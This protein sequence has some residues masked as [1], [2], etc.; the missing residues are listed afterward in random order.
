MALG[1]HT[2]PRR[3]PALVGS[4]RGPRPSAGPPTAPPPA[5]AA[6]GSPGAGSVR[7]GPGSVY[8]QQLPADRRCTSAC[9]AGLLSSAP[10]QPGCRPCSPR[11]RGLS[12]PVGAARAPGR[13]GAR[14]SPPGRARMR[15]CRG[16]ASHAPGMVRRG[17]EQRGHAAQP[18]TPVAAL[19]PLGFGHSYYSTHTR[20]EGLFG[21]SFFIPTLDLVL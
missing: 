12:S 15:P 19:T 10:Q 13:F 8:S 14:S 17:A 11:P 18:P 3:Q 20:A 6:R 7:R 21:V 4:E 2:Q 5:R 16:P 1:N 9:F